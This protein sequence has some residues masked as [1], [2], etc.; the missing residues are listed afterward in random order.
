M[1]NKNEK[2]SFFDKL[3]D[4]YRLSLYRDESYEEVLNLRLSRM[5]VFALGGTALF[6]FLAIVVSLIA[7]TPIREFIP[8]YP[9]ENTLRTI[10]MNA[11]RL[12]SLENEL[13]RRDRYFDNMRT[14]ITGGVPNNHENP[15]DTSKKY[16]DITFSRSIED[17]M[18]RQRF[19][20]EVGLE[21]SAYKHREHFVPISQ[22]HFFPPIKGIVTNSFQSSSNHFGTDVVTGA[23]AAVKSTLDGTVTLAA[24]TL[25][26]GWV[27]QIQ[28]SN[29]LLSIYKHNAELL[30]RVG[31][32]VRAGDPIAIIGNSGELTTGP[33]LHFEL[34]YNGMALNPEDYVSF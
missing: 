33:H 5:N 19:E 21:L 17:S 7:Y 32:Y 4:K 14:I 22:L 23:D 18:I 13:Q 1:A 11:H 26:T 24:W 12:D 28:H 8:G 29:N 2:P 6:I 27:I 16:T 15:G 30:K 20:D 31:D 34:W 9:D 3:K 25:E 10:V